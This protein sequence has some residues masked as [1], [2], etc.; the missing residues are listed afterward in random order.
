MSYEPDEEYLRF[1]LRV[2]CS[3]LVE[4]RGIED[5]K[6]RGQALDEMLERALFTPTASIALHDLVRAAPAPES[7]LHYRPPSQSTA[8]PSSR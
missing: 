7:A 6:E 1:Y 2:V 8:L 5:P 4:K 3:E